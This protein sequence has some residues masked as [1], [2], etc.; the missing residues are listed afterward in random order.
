MSEP[1]KSAA[2]GDRN[3]APTTTAAED[4]VP[5]GQRR[6]NLIWEIT[7]AFVAISVTGSTLYVAA[8][9][10]VKGGTETPFLLLS[11]AFF[12][13]VGTYITRTNHQKI[14]GV[15]KNDTGR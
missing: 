6:I 3:I 9:L 8:Q 7:Q 15:G 2:V 11:N 4:A 1:S 10:A 5:A 13:V 14:G 12:L